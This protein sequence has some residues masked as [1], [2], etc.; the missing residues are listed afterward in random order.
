[1]A[2]LE[3]GANFFQTHAPGGVKDTIK[4]SA[5][6]KRN[7][8][9]AKLSTS[10]RISRIEN[11]FPVQWFSDVLYPDLCPQNPRRK[12]DPLQLLLI[13]MRRKS[14]SWPVLQPLDSNQ[15]YLDY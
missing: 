1:M 11:T 2:L 3:A 15:H 12:S 6:P 8:V 10:S 5:L 14:H 9:R 13:A 4:V 7:F